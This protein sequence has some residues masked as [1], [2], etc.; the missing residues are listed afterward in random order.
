MIP[1]STCCGD[2]GNVSKSNTPQKYGIFSCSARCANH[3]SLSPSS[4][5]TSWFIPA[6][7]DGLYMEGVNRSASRIEL[8]DWH[9]WRW[10]HNNSRL[11]KFLLQSLQ[12]YVDSR[13]GVYLLLC[14]AS[15]YTFYHNE[16][17][18][19]CWPGRSEALN[20]F[21][22]PFTDIYTQLQ[23]PNIHSNFLS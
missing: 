1:Q 13:H 2:D 3:S 4:F 14:R 12:R 22:N 7:G 11:T 19:T 8:V 21:P 5:L 20:D 10:L 9:F 16:H 17:S 18:N 6:P 23:M 15:L